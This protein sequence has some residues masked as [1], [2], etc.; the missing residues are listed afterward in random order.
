M[1]GK[2]Y[3][4]S[5]KKLDEDLTQKEKQK[6][7]SEITLTDKLNKNLLQSFLTRI[8]QS[9]DALEKFIEADDPVVSSGD[10][11]FH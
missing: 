5:Q 3:D 7:A 2:N 8:N 1:P 4:N 9:D 10:N 6:Q 11:E